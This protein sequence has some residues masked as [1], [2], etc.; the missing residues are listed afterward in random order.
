M[1]IIKAWE[2][3][4]D[5]IRALLTRPFL[6]E[7]E[8]TEE[9]SARTKT[10]W[11]ESLSPRQAVRRILDDVKNRGD[12]AVSKYA[13]KLDGAQLER[14]QFWVSEAEWDQAL[15]KVSPE[16]MESLKIAHTNIHR[17]HAQQM[18]KGWVLEEPLGIILGQ[19]ITPLDKVGIYVPGGSAPLVSTVLMCGV[20]ARVAGVREI[21]MTSPVGSDGVMNPHILA[22]AR[23]AGIH[24]VLKLGGAQAV[25]ALAYG[26]DSIA[27]V[28]KI[29]GPGN[30]YVT[31][32]KQM[33]FG[34]VGI[35]SLAGPSEIT[36]IADE[37]ANAKYTAADLLSQAEHDPEAAA[38]LLTDSHCLAEAVADEL[39]KQLKALGRKTTAAKSLERHGLILVCEDLTQAANWSNVIAPEH[40]ELCVADPWRLLHLIRHAGAIFLGHWASEPIGDYVAGPNHVLPTNGTARFS[41]PLGV[42]DFVKRSSII[43]YTEEGL[44][45]FGPHAVRLASIEGLD[46]HAGAVSV[47]LDTERPDK[48]DS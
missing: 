28:D 1:R 7:A 20:P 39:T 29:V 8:V 40:L 17:Y 11:G 5:E 27:S 45:K 37:T 36:V 6:D 30:I 42:E 10:I 43:S 24:R 14:D 26:T 44:E 18:P 19:R 23:I 12:A 41:S 9:A 13:L 47:R 16:F 46:A 15:E 31:L 21:V 38:I 2:T 48:V 33:V 4:E 22:A 25:A 35:E 34:R 32:A 3:G